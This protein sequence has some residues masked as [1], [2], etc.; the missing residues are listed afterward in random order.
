MSEREQD[1]YTEEQYRHLCEL[2]RLFLEAVVKKQF[3]GSVEPIP[4]G[5]SYAYRSG[6][7]EIA[8]RHL[9]DSVWEDLFYV[10][11]HE[12]KHHYDPIQHDGRGGREERA[13]NYGRELVRQMKEAVFAFS[14]VKESEIGVC[15]DRRLTKEE[16]IDFFTSRLVKITDDRL[17]ARAARE[18]ACLM[19]ER[20]YRFRHLEWTRGGEYGFI[21]RGNLLR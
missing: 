19:V 8:H 15:P 17:E 3:P 14:G 11:A 21:A 2:G 12:F 4:G 5:T 16:K 18:V 6:R 13:M 1:P 20:D 7:T 10:F 9:E